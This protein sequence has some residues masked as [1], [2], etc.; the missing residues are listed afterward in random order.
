MDATVGLYELQDNG[1]WTKNSS[2]C[3]MTRHPNYSELQNCII[4]QADTIEELCDEFVVGFNG[5]KNN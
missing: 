2:L 1:E 4:K 5:K 3:L